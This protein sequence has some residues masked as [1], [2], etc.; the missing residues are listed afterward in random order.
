MAKNNSLISIK[1]TIDGMTFYN[2]NGKNY[3]RTISK[4]TKIFNQ[5]QKDHVNEFKIASSVSAV[6]CNAIHPFVVGIIKPVVFKPVFGKLMEMR[7]Y[8]TQSKRG[9]RSCVEAMKDENSLQELIGLNFNTKMCLHKVL[10]VK[11]NLDKARNVLTIAGLN[12]R[13]QLI[14]PKDS[15]YFTIEMAIIKL[16]LVNNSADIQL[17]E[18]FEGDLNDAKVDVNLIVND[19][20]TAKGVKLFLLKILFYDLLNGEKYISECEDANVCAIIDATMV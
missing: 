13:L 11:F 3:I 10:R 17:S 6:L 2:M 16:D 9:L 1:G 15:A 20:T 14:A 5:K 12:P 8:D 4:K 18:V 7:K 19:N